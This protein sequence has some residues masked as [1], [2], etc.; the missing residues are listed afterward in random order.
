MSEPD[1]SLPGMTASRPAGGLP[2]NPA[3]LRLTYIAAQHPGEP[4]E[5]DDVLEWSHVTVGV[6][7]D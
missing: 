2:A 6:D 5:F 7:H 4:E 1:A 3:L